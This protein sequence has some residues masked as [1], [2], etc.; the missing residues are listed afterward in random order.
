LRRVPLDICPPGS[1]YV[2][3]TSLPCSKSMVTCLL[4]PIQYRKMKVLAFEQ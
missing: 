3:L 1:S 2:L 4:K